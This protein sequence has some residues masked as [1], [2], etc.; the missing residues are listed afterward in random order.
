MLGS[1]TQ[2]GIM[3]HTMCELFEQIENMSDEKAVEVSVSYLEVT[4]L[5]FIVNFLFNNILDL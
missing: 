5:F 2:R 4:N 1:S 3:Y